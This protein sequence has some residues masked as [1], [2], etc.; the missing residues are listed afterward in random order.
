MAIE[1]RARKDYK[2]AGGKV[3]EEVEYIGPDY[4]SGP[5]LFS[6]FI[7]LKYICGLLLIVSKW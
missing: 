6:V 4:K 5:I 7:I 1:F 3:V 2:R